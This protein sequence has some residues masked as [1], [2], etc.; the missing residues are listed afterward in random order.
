MSDF[1]I[2]FVYP[3]VLLLLIPAIGLALYSYFRT[4]K[5]YRRNRNRITSL[6]LHIT[7]MVLSIFA[8][9][10]LNFTYNL[11]NDENEL[12]LV[13][14]AS[15]S[16]LA[17][18]AQ[19]D[20]FVRRVIDSSEGTNKVGVV[21]FGYDQVYA[22]PLSNDTDEIYSQY[23]AARKPNTTATDIASALTYARGLFSHPD[24]A[25][26]VL[27]SDG[28]ETD[29]NALD[30]IKSVAASGVCVD[31]VRYGNEYNDA[32]V[33][34]TE[35]AFPDYDIAVDMEF[36]IT[37]RMESRILG[38]IA[39]SVT[40]N[41]ES[42]TAQQVSVGNGAQT[43]IINHAFSERGLHKLEFKIESTSD[44]VSENNVY[45]AYYYI[46][47]FEDVLIIAND[48]SSAAALHDLLEEEGHY[49]VEIAD[50]HDYAQMPN[51]LEEL[52][53]YDEVVLFNISNIDMPDGFIDILHT[54][55]DELGGGLF[56]V[57][58]DR[59]DALTGETIPN[60]YNRNDMLEDGKPTLYQEMLPV[61]AINYT[62]PVGVMIVVDCSGSM[63]GLIEEAQNGAIE[64]LYSLSDRDWCGIMALNDHYE[65][66]QT[67]LPLTQQNAL[68]EA[69]RSIEVSGSTS[70]APSIEYAG[71]ALSAL[72]EVELRH[73]VLISDGQPLD[74]HEGYMEKIRENYARGITFSLI[75]VGNPSSEENMREAVAAGGGYYYDTVNED[76]SISTA[77]RQ[78]LGMDEIKEYN[79]K[80]FKPTIRTYTSV[81]HNINDE[82]IP[83]LGGFYGTKDKTDKSVRTVLTGEY[84]PIYVQ[85]E[86]GKGRVGSFMSELSGLPGSWSESW[87]SDQVGR[88]LLLNMVDALFPW[89]SIKYSDLDVETEE[90]NY[91]TAVNVY[92]SLEDG[93]SIE[94]TV[95]GPIPD[96]EGETPPKYTV[97]KGKDEGYSRLTFENLQRGV[98]EVHIRKLG[99]DGRAIAEYRTFRAF[100]YSQEYN[101]WVDEQGA[102]ELMQDIARVGR[103]K[104][105]TSPYDVFEGF[106]EILPDGFDPRTLFI[107]LALVLFLLDIAVRKFK[108]KWIH[109][110]VREHKE[111]KMSGNE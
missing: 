98:Y 45:T 47:T 62:P 104:V 18:E 91:R 68:I 42:V 2:N 16:N 64:A 53:L 79:P 49:V 5:K 75:I 36:E 1:S 4:A 84:V 73:I 58:G 70:Y 33:Q 37:V 23:K 88:Q 107:I 48:P 24:S 59:V 27:I 44:T 56:T 69:I 67:L 106:V 19:K 32:E 101:M 109:E 103:G 10:G 26:I 12:L 25:K 21:T 72:S 8:L 71:R 66:E 63:T 105:I 15:Y 54:Y 57:G 100:S 43:V 97:V 38:T 85:W 51:T 83:E 78:D 82:D 31:T 7:V 92:T 50:V 22:A 46:E 39:L 3:W 41:G 17:A 102:T 20:D 61:Q 94:M 111:K 52:R 80:P 90:D 86:Y 93:Q 96:G 74:S 89:Q 87:M 28:I 76:I 110:L 6:V 30:A 77:L 65:T 108:W 29:S 55:V 34:I 60:A 99:V 13:V 81:V 40:D 95:T 11:V 35:V 9:S 14:D